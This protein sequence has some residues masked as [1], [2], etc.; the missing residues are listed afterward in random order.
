MRDY[1]GGN[2]YYEHTNGSVHHKPASVVDYYD[3]GPEEYF[4][5]PFVKLWWYEPLDE[6]INTSDILETDEEWFK[7]AKLMKF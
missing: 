4:D 1:K 2:Y 7:E 3:G 6:E 5:S